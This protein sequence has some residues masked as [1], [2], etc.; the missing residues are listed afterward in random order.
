MLLSR[1]YHSSGYM[2]IVGRLAEDFMNDA[3][4]E[5]KALFE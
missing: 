3:V 1:L 4:G 2:K 5:V